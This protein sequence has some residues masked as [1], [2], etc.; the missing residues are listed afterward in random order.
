MNTARKKWWLPHRE[1]HG[2]PLYIQ[3]GWPGRGGEMASFVLDMAHT[4]QIKFGTMQGYVWCVQVDH[5]H[6]FGASGDP[7]D[8]VADWGKFMSALEVQSFVNSS[9]EPRRM[10][11]FMMLVNTLLCLD[12]SVRLEAGLG[13]MMLMMYYTMSRSESPLPKTANS[14]DSTKHIRRCDVRL[15]NSMYVEWGLGSIKQ[16]QRSKR[17]NRDPDK[18]DWKPCGECDGVLSMRNWFDAYEELSNWSDGQQPFFYDD[19]GKPLT[20]TFMLNF[21]RSCMARC[22]GV[23]QA[24]ADLY[25][26]HGLRVLGYNCWR[27]AEGED[28]AALQGGWGSLAHRL[29]GRQMLMKILGMAEKGAHYAAANALAPMPLD[30]ALPPQTVTTP[31]A[32]PNVVQPSRPGPSDTSVPSSS[33][34]PVSDD[35]WNGLPADAVEEMRTPKGRAYK[36]WKWNL[37]VFASKS[38]VRK[39]YLKSNFVLALQKMGYGMRSR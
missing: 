1:K 22:D 39:A 37:N 4:E 15:L 17:S 5:I 36:V 16:D 38:K 2:L 24:D 34:T 31:V 25:G 30:D 12:S 33:A 20:Y 18:R 13:C 35:G 8:G 6:Q 26:F 9:V 29:Y 28:V 3:P 27:A 19:N 21:M 23:S 10:M 32:V 11:P 7:L 14:F